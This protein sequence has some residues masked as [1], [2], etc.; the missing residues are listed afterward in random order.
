MPLSIHPT[1]ARIV[2]QHKNAFNYTTK[3]TIIILAAC[4]LLHVYRDRATERPG[5]ARDEQ[6][7]A[8]RDDTE[9]VGDDLREGPYVQLHELQ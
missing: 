6:T 4:R 2:E 1:A 3:I 5:A 9:A 7:S 8:Q